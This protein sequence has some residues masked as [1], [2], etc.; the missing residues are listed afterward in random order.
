MVKS[1][2]TMSLGLQHN[3]IYTYKDWEYKAILQDIENRCFIDGIIKSIQRETETL[4]SMFGGTKYWTFR[5]GNNART[6][7]IS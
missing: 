3:G 1:I 5:T 7:F 2:V 4:P 6:I